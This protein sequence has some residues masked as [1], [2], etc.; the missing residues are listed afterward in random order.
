M[1]ERGDEELLQFAHKHQGAFSTSRLIVLIF[2]TQSTDDQPVPVVVV[3]TQYDRL[4][5]AELADL[6]DESGPGSK[7]DSANLRDR[8]MEEARKSFRKSLDSLQYNMRRLGIPM[9]PHVA[10]S[11]KF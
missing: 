10:V 4:V 8:S 3:F 7:K 1:F 2:N 5:R 11:G 9:P 6:Q